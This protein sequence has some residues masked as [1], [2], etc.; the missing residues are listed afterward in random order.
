MLAELLQAT[1]DM[2]GQVTPKLRMFHSQ[3]FFARG[4]GFR[5]RTVCHACLLASLDG[6]LQSFFKV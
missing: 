1:F 4:I 3:F 2:F 6:A 5:R